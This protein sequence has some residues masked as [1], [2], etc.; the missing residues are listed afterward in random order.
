MPFTTE[1]EVKGEALKS[2]I[3]YETKE[4]ASVGA[5]P[6]SPGGE[7]TP[8]QHSR[9]HDDHRIFRRHSN[10]MCST[11]VTNRTMPVISVR[12]CEPRM[13]VSDASEVLLRYPGSNTV[14]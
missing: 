12:T 13:D 10:Y 7:I 14:Q 2:T 4:A 1:S 8:Q 11:T 5:Q 6:A 3:E 9:K